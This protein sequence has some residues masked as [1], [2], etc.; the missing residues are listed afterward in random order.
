MSWHRTD[1]PP[2]AGRIGWRHWVEICRAH[3]FQIL[4]VRFTR[5]A[6]ATLNGM[7]DDDDVSLVGGCY[8]LNLT[9]I[10]REDEL[11]PASEPYGRV[12]CLATVQR[13]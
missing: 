11:L 13:Q 6:D 3:I 4:P 5:A 1:V 12:R 7:V 8:N 10:G 9:P 2:D